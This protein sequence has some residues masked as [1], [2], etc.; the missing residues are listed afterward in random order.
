MYWHFAAFWNG[1]QKCRGLRIFM[2]LGAMFLGF[3]L[4]IRINSYNILIKFKTKLY[5]KP[6]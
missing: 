6:N 3:I 2:G 5:L 4:G 1:E